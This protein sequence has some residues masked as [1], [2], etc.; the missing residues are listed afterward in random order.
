MGNIYISKG[1]EGKS[2]IIIYA[3]EGPVGVRTS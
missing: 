3:R 2:I 1:N